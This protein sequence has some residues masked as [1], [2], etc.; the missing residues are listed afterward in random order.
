M[1][2]FVDYFAKIKHGYERTRVI[3]SGYGKN[4][5]LADV[6]YLREKKVPDKWNTHH[7]QYPRRDAIFC[8]DGCDKYCLSWQCTHFVIL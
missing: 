1:I 8:Y 5:V 6:Y 7:I 3:T 2:S 4:G